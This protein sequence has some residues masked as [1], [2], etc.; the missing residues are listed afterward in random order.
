MVKQPRFSVSVPT[1]E[2]HHVSQW[3]HWLTALLV[4]AILP[5]AWVMTSMADDN[6][7]V[8]TLFMIHKSLGVTIFVLVAFRIFWRA[9]NPPPPLPWS[10]E[11]W[12]SILAKVSHVLLYL[13]LLAM[14]ISGYILSSA[15]DHP[16]NFFNLFKLPLLPEDKPLAKVAQNVHLALQWAVYALVGLHILA[17][18]WHI[19]VRRD[20]VLNRMLPKQINA[21]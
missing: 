8:R 19:F 9:L 13:I 12:E 2:Y 10:L 7:W 6:P 18:S 11:P 16:V 15:S 20:G 17:T 14:P 3:L 21:E 1:E 4:F 5:I